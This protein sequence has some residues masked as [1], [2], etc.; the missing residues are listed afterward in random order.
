VSDD[1]LDAIVKQA[2]T[3]DREARNQVAL[4]VWRYASREAT[5]YSERTGLE[6]DELMSIALCAVPK[7]VGVW[8]SKKGRFFTF[9]AAIVQQ[10]L[11]NYLKREKL[12]RPQFQPHES[13]AEFPQLVSRQDGVSEEVQEVLENLPAELAEI[14]RLR[15]GL[16]VKKVKVQT[17]AK[18]MRLPRVITQILFDV[19]V[20][21]F[22]RQYEVNNED[23]S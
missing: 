20:E 7:A 12:R 14:L 15:F 22:R 23:H 6:R 21:V 19:A 3:G 16:G 2:Q 1:P 5:R 18:L 13:V 4:G 17:A 8:D 10:D 11:L 9:Y